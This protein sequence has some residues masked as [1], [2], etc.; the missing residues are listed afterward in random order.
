MNNSIL[1]TGGNGFIGKNLA[2][3]ARDLGFK[4]R[5]TLRYNSKE[6]NYFPDSSVLL[7]INSETV[8]TSALSGVKAVVHCAAHVHVMNI[9][10]H[11]S[12]KLFR[13]VNVD[14][15]LNLARQAALAG[16]RRFIFISSIKVN[17]ESTK[18]GTPFCANDNPN[19]QDPYSISKLEAE[20]GLRELATQTGMEV[21]IIRPPLVY[22]PGVKA[23]FLNM[24]NWL[25]MGIPM[26]LGG[27]VKNCRSFVFI[28]NLVNMIIICI[29]HPSA[30]NQTFLVSDDEDLS[31]AELIKRINI[32]LGRPSKLIVVPSGLIKLGAQLIRR[33]D[34]V[35]RLCGS[36]QVDINKTKEFLGWS[37]PYSVSEGLHKTAIH[38]LDKKS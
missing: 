38:F 36:L 1:I 14:G 28:D 17:G 19:P 22:G 21:V 37:A 7:N 16:V 24:I 23:N 6:I 20:K 12:L 3:N 11:D 5:V 2:I 29:N 9:Q 32:A 27:V 10:D 18:L 30:A 8:W 31:T 35:Q 4:V 13:K 33:P 25:K 15:T 34:I 26:P